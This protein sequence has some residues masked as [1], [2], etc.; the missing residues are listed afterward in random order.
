[1]TDEIIEDFKLL[2]KDMKDIAMTYW[3]NM[4]LGKDKEN[5]LIFERVKKLAEKENK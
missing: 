4:R 5:E 1:M 3:E 2:P